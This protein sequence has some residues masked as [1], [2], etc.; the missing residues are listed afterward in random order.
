M[1]Y[2]INSLKGPSK[3]LAFVVIVLEC[4]DMQYDMTWSTKEA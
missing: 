2:E 4:M 3:L 1:E